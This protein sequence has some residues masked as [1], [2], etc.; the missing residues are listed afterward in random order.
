[1]NIKKSVKGLI[2]SIFRII[3][4]V[5]IGLLILNWVNTWNLSKAIEGQHF[6]VEKVS[7]HF[8]VYGLT[9]DCQE[10]VKE[11]SIFLEGFLDYLNREYMTFDYDFPIKVYIWPDEDSFQQFTQKAR[12][13]GSFGFFSPLTKSFYT[14]QGSGFGTLTHELMHPLLKANLPNLPGWGEEGIPT[15]FEKFFGYWDDGKLVIETGYQSSWRI[16]ELGDDLTRLKLKEIV[17][18]PSKNQ[19]EL[20]LASV[21]LGKYGLLKNYLQLVKN[22]NKKGFGSYYEAA[23]GKRFSDIESLWKDYLYDIDLHKGQL[24]QIPPSQ[25]FESKKDYERF[26]REYDLEYLHKF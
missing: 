8:I 2:F 22:K 9:A 21:F 16:D 18:E 25:V 17:E 11:Y 15:F 19:S 10:S 24:E 4:G 7:K 3:I 12:V 5:G 20:R 1:M 26:I 6:S 13:P 14:F 23:F